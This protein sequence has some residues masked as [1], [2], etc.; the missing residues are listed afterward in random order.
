M[1]SHATPRHAMLPA[2]S[3]PQVTLSLNST[4]GCSPCHLGLCQDTPR[5][6]H[7]GSA[8]RRP[9]P[10]SEPLWRGGQDR[11]DGAVLPLTPEWKA[12]GLCVGTEVTEATPVWR[13]PLRGI[14]HPLRVLQAAPLSPA[15]A[16]A[17]L[18]STSALQ[19]TAARPRANVTF[20]SKPNAHEMSSYP[21]PTQRLPIISCFKGQ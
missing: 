8:R 14:A 4:K 12:E 19:P 21:Q 18:L 13:G 10:H 3:Q 15:A 11:P 20:M 16:T 2:A 6:R 5:L 1:P 7:D 17:P 9:C